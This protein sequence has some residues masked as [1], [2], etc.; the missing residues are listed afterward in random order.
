MENFEELKKQM[1]LADCEM[2][3]MLVLHNANANKD[4]SYSQLIDLIKVYRSKYDT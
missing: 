1:E 4:I 2:D 3:Y